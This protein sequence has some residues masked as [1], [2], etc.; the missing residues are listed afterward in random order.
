MRKLVS[1]NDACRIL[2]IGKTKIY[3]LINDGTLLS[4]KIGRRRLIVV[5]SIDAITGAAA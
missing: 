1:I 3:E 4:V 2:A 5:D